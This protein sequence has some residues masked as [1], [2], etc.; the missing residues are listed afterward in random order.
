MS[1][2]KYYSSLTT[3][4]AIF[5]AIFVYAVILLY[6]THGISCDEGFY[7]LG[8]LNNQN[9]GISAYD[10]HYIVRAITPDKYE[11]NVVFYRVLRFTLDFASV[12]F[13]AFTSYK[14]L[15]KRFGF[16][17]NFCLFAALIVLSGAISY[18]Y[19][20]LTISF[21]H[22]QHIFYLSA[23]SFFF[24]SDITK[25]EYAKIIN[26]IFLGFFLLLAIVNYLPS[27]ILLSAT[28]IILFFV[29]NKPKIASQYSLYLVFGIILSGV[30]YNFAI[31]NLADFLKNAIGY[32]QVESEGATSHNSLSLLTN[33][34]K[35]IGV[36]LLWQIPAVVFALII[37]KINN[38]WLTAIS[39]I[40]LILSSL[41]FRQIYTLGG[42]LLFM[43][44]T[45]LLVNFFSKKQ[46]FSTFLIV[47]I[48]TFIPFAG[49]F[50]TN[51]DVLHKL[52]IFFPFWILLFF[53][54]L[55]NTKE[56]YDRWLVLF[57][58]TLITASSVYLGNF[59]R[60]HCYY[61]PRS[62]K[63]AFAQG[64]RYK[65]ILISKYQQ[66]YYNQL[67]DTLKSVGFTSGETAVA[68][69]ENQIAVYLLGGNFHGGLVYSVNQYVIVP[70]E[71]AKYLILFQFEENQTVKQLEKSDWN[72]PTD[73]QRIELGIMSENMTDKK[74]QTILYYLRN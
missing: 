30:F 7:L 58:I 34:L 26:I 1:K 5:A 40:L 51:Q 43:P 41:Y 50:G 64:E 12:L 62:S 10:F 22:L 35:S 44:V 11:A 65:D 25:K 66:N 37:K 38:K 47:L 33:V 45:F 2:S 71:R 63:Y 29:L 36:F 21:D 54:L 56:N 28:I 55:K 4:Y 68:F 17:V 61:T 52:L 24:I 18:N 39:F 19:A 20:A 23:F 6:L 8:Y 15:K 67:E 16:S 32:M 42:S 49:V 69:G 74:Y 27:G 59:S 72:F 60:Y 9:I 73:Y 57:A 70:K 14:W 48:L 31:H 53:I 3:L 46:H 13:F